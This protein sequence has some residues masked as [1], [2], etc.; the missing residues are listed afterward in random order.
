MSTSIETGALVEVRGERWRLAATS[1][2]ASCAVLTL[3]GC[4]R[5]NAT[6]RLMVIEPFE[7]SRAITN[8]LMRRPRRVVLQSALGAIVDARAPGSLWTAA[9]AAMA[10]WPYQLEPALAVITGATRLLL[11]DAVGLGKTIQA[12]LILAELRARGWIER[13][14]IVCPAGLRETWARE[15]ASRFNIDAIPLDQASI[16]ERLAS[17]PPGM[18]PWSG[19]RV[20]IASIDFIKQ[21]EV[22]AA[23][24]AEPI[25][26]LIAD[27]AHHLTPGT[28][29]GGAIARLAARA[30]WL[31]LMSAT[32]HSGD[33]AA[34]NYLTG[35]GAHGDALTMFRRSRTDAGLESRRRSHLLPLRP[36][37]AEA[38]LFDGIDR[39]AQAMSRERGRDDHTIRLVAITLLRRAASS[40]GAILRT[41]MRRR[42][43][44]DSATPLPVQPPLP[45][46][47]NDASDDVEADALLATP[48]LQD[49]TEECAMVSQLIEMAQSCGPGA[50]LR[51]LTRLLDRIPEPI[52]VFTEYRDSLEAVVAHLR[53]ARRVAAIHGGMPAAIRQAAVDAFNDGR[54]DVLIAT[55]AAGEGLN[56][57]HR[58][59]V[60]IDLE[61]PWNPLRLEQR[62]G[63]VDRLGQQ[64]TVHAFRLFYPGTIEAHVLSHLTRREH[65]AAAAFHRH[66]AMPH[67]IDE[68]ARINRQRRAHRAGAPAASGATWCAPRRPRWTRFVLVGRRAATNALGGVMG[69]AIEAHVVRLP[70]ARTPGQW[71]RLITSAW[72]QSTESFDEAAAAPLLAAATRD[73][74]ER[75]IQRIRAHLAR[76]RIEQQGSLFDRRADTQREQREQSLTRLNDALTRTQS[77]IGSHASAQAQLDLI[78]A[79]PETRR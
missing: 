26:L 19:H 13:A 1:S 53:S 21:P 25:D 2:Y 5:G 7:R 8:R 57:H 9:S 49:V 17:L 41:L 30:T 37:E 39:Y 55:D 12:G 34:F 14:L 69:E 15:L 63:R 10:V 11:A 64:G 16:T 76:I 54:I 6:Q 27:E 32:P 66:P 4:D 48:G 3:E 75:R 43:L 71:R 59:R 20:A 67:A 65:R 35:L 47:E 61:L 60:V 73:R 29:R 42:A 40:A 56:L 28:D 45:W 46:E 22:L 51:R 79:W 74:I 33:A 77:A 36:T 18:N 52:V 50:K 70:Q 24:E 78:A 58:S 44:L 68:A 31:V 72:A 23:I 62:V 38:A